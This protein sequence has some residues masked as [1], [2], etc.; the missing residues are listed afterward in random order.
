[1]TRESAKE[2]IGRGKL[3]LLAGKSD[4]PVLDFIPLQKMVRKERE[5]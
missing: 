2:N 3:S 1:M 4:L 5:A